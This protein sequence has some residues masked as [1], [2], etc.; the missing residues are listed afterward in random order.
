MAPKHAVA[1]P[2]EEDLG[3]RKNQHQLESEAIL[4]PTSY[5]GSSH[6]TQ[7]LLIGQKIVQNTKVFLNAVI[8]AV[9]SPLLA[10]RGISQHLA[11]KVITMQA[12]VGHFSVQTG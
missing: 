5:T 2:S 10:T 8:N 1:I 3:A 6:K 12:I 11:Q 4:R 9:I 7:Y